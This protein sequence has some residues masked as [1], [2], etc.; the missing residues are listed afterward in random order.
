MDS[1]SF[2]NHIQ[3]TI[4]DENNL[5][6][7]NLFLGTPVEKATDPYWK[8]ALSLFQALPSNEQEVFFEIIRQIA[9]DTTS[10]VLAVIDD[11]DDAS[12]FNGDLQ[13]MFLVEEEKRLKKRI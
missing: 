1:K 13:S 11:M 7:R 9:V 4:I 6:Y 5:I 8:K 2:I 12:T 10:N 3:S